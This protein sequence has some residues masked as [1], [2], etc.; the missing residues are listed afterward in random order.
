M[1]GEVFLALKATGFLRISKQAEAEGLDVSRRSLRER[2]LGARPGRS[3]PSLSEGHSHFHPLKK[4]PAPTFG[5]QNP[6]QCHAIRNF[7]LLFQCFV[8]GRHEFSPKPSPKMVKPQPVIDEVNCPLRRHLLSR[9]YHASLHRVGRT[10][11]Q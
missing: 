7:H 5:L 10:T 11:G 2:E 6:V 8:L 9:I 1:F 4:L 3:D